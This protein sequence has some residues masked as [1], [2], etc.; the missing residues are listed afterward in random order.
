[1][2]G[3]HWQGGCRRQLP[4]LSLVQHRAGLACRD[5]HMIPQIPPAVTMEPLS[6][7]KQKNKAE[8]PRGGLKQGQT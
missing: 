2:L 7:T 6:K 4:G 8:A 3:G 1:M 5:P